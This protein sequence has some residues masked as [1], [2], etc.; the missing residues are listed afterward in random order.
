[1]LASAAASAPAP[2]D[3]HKIADQLAQ[4]LV[5]MCGE[6]ERLP[7]AAC[8]CK[9][10]AKER[11]GLLREVSAFDLS[12]KQQRDQAYRAVR[13]TYLARVGKDAAVYRPAVPTTWVYFGLVGLITAAGVVLLLLPRKRAIHRHRR[14]QRRGH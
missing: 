1:M 3:A 4:D 6:C 13:A 2:D 11:E 8:S 7:L 10:A 14:P 12:T 5:C 9:S